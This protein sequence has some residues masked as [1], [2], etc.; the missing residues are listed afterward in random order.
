[1]KLVRDDG[2]G[3]QKEVMDSVDLIV[4]ILAKAAEG[5]A[6]RDIV[7]DW[8]KYITTIVKTSPAERAAAY[9]VAFRWFGVP[10]PE[11]TPQT[12]DDGYNTLVI[13]QWD[14]L[15]MLLNA[16][17]QQQNEQ[18][19][20]WAAKFDT[21]VQVKYPG[22]E[23]QYIQERAAAYTVALQWFGVP[24]PERTP[25]NPPQAPEGSTI[26][27]KPVIENY[28]RELEIE[29]QF[30]NQMV[31]L[32]WSSLRDRR[33]IA[34]R[35]NEVISAIN[36]PTLSNE[37]WYIGLIDNIKHPETNLY[38]AV[39]YGT[40]Y[41][42]VKTL[43]KQSTSQGRE[44][45]NV[46]LDCWVALVGRPDYDPSIF[47]DD[48]NRSLLTYVVGDMQAKIGH[49]FREQVND[50][51]VFYEVWKKYMTVVNRSVETAGKYVNGHNT[52]TLAIENCSDFGPGVW[53]DVTSTQ[54]V[55]DMGERPL[56]NI[57]TTHPHDLRCFSVVAALLNAKHIDVVGKNT[58]NTPLYTACA[59]EFRWPIVVHL[60][61]ILKDEP[62][63]RLNDLI[64]DETA[65]QRAVQH[66]PGAVIALI[67]QPDLMPNKRE[68]GGQTAL[69]L[70][71][72][73]NY[74]GVLNQEQEKTDMV[75]NALPHVGA[76]GASELTDA[77]KNLTVGEYTTT[78]F[79]W[80]AQT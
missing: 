35:V 9:T 78:P 4:K 60:L 36:D 50:D 79:E 55:E 22:D 34:L 14:N 62:N 28:H 10:L 18:N 19:R 51:A 52:L 27:I 3:A 37:S 30:Y 21:L 66:S 32:T 54:M 46:M 45:T 57:A 47:Y 39:S 59:H 70:V 67:K 8:D 38:R 42:I 71:Q 77:N 12:S 6:P 44:V 48:D 64:Y 33:N 80:P 49:T 2:M 74:L 73:N 16:I 43:V 11:R 68:D 31:I 75:I 25:P 20:D 23:H 69:D 15:K 17:A 63:N 56:S 5:N 61:D 72:C 26:I 53:R 65:F 76:V 29:K 41:N 24:L 13:T 40:H 7:E 1:M 58:H